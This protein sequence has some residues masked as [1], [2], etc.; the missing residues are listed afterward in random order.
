PRPAAVAAQTLE[1]TAVAGTLESRHEV[2]RSHLLE[3]VEREL[4]RLVDQP[5]N[6]EPERCRV[7]VRV[8]VMLCR[9]ELVFR[10]ERT[11]DRS[12][13][14]P[15]L[16]GSR[17]PS[18]VLGDVGEGHERVALRQR[19]KHPLRNPDDAEPC[20]SQTTLENLAPRPLIRHGQSLSDVAAILTRNGEDGAITALSP[21]AVRF[22]RI[23]SNARSSARRRRRNIS[24]RYG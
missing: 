7:D 21:S 10:R 16:V 6:F 11:V 9:C 5:R 23:P 2:A 14:Q 20:Q 19:R 8:S 22:P 18:G 12:N 13:V 24:R 3:I 17:F 4:L 15:P 1:W